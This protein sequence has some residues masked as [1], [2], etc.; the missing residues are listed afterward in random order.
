MSTDT[1]AESISV[2]HAG[3][4]RPATVHIAFLDG[5]RGLS[6]LYVVLCHWWCQYCYNA[7]LYG[8]YVNVC[9]NAKWPVDTFI[10]ISGF[11]LMIPVAKYGGLRGGA[12]EFFKRRAW[13]IVPPY[14]CA[15]ALSMLLIATVVGHKTGTHWDCSIPVSLGGVLAHLALLQDLRG[16]W[17]CMI[18]HALWT[19]SVEWRIYFLFPLF[20]WLWRKHNTASTLIAAAI[21]SFIYFEILQ[22]VHPGHYSGFSCPHYILLFVFGMAGASLAYTPDQ[23]T[24]FASL[25]MCLF[26]VAAAWAKLA[27]YVFRESIG[28]SLSGPILTDIMIGLISA[29]VVTYA[30]MNATSL[31]TR[32]LAWK[33]LAFMGTFAYSIYLVHAPLLQCEWLIFRRSH[34]DDSLAFTIGCWLGI[35]IVVGLSYVFFWYCERPFLRKRG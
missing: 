26:L 4:R 23:S 32:A 16:Q 5:L 2:A 3:G 29:A 8:R 10:V 18:N 9:S 22:H 20:V 11:C 17:A 25:G 28:N 13:R 1:L 6:A 15:I 35:P 33:P 31:V 14:Y 19:V 30:A 24:R 34:I 7:A 12:V 27:L 21:C